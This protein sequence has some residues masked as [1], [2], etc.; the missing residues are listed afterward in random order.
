V[1]LRR[2]AT[3]TVTRPVTDEPAAAPA[4]NACRL[5][6]FDIAPLIAALD[7]AIFSLTLAQLM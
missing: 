3:R 5:D 6:I 4:R 7:F 1:I 2:L